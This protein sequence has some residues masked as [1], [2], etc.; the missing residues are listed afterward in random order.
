MVNLPKPQ[1]VVFKPNTNPFLVE[2]IDNQATKNELISQIE[3]AFLTWNVKS[4]SKAHTATGCFTCLLLLAK[5]IPFSMLAF[6]SG[7]RASRALDS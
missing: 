5:A 2:I 3:M 4:K 6:S 7:L 1:Q